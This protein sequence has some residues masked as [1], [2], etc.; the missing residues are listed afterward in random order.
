MYGS[1]PGN[2]DFMLVSLS[3]SVDAT[4]WLSYHVPMAKVDAV[5]VHDGR[6]QWP[7][8]RLTYGD[9]HVPLFAR[10]A[11]IVVDPSARLGSIQ[12]RPAAAARGGHEDDA[13][14]GLQGDA[15]RRRAR[16]RA[17]DR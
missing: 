16:S 8:R 11:A 1:M 13:A 3:S 17:A 5:L 12:G 7:Q 4:T 2:G 9:L 10:I 6:L 14:G 15:L